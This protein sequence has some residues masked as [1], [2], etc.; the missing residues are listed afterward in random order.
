MERVQINEFLHICRVMLSL[1]QFY[2]PSK[3]GGNVLINIHFPV[4]SPPLGS[5]LST[6][7]PLYLPFSGILFVHRC[8]DINM[9][10]IVVQLSYVV[11][12]VLDLNFFAPSFIGEL[13][14]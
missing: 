7:V 5:H 8:L 3:D 9:P 6:S 10:R 4:S 2:F 13:S 14:F 11:F 1:T 12:R